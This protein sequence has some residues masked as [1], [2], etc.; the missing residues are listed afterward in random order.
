M[1]SRLSGKCTHLGIE[2]WVEGLL[3][4]KSRRTGSSGVTGGELGRWECRVLYLKKGLLA[5]CL[6]ARA[7]LGDDKALGAAM[8]PEFCVA[9]LEWSK[10]SSEIK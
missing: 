10:R 5:P 3:V 1:I 2:A 7:V 9:V 8:R 4:L 6:R